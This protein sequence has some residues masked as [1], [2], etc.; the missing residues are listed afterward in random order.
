MIRLAT[1]A[2]LYARIPTLEGN[3]KIHENG[4]TLVIEQKTA[5][6][7]AMISRLY[8][9]PTLEDNPKSWAILEDICIELC[10]G[11]LEATLQVVIEDGEGGQKLAPS[12]E[13]AEKR[14]EMIRAG[15]LDLPDA[16]RCETCSVAKGG[17]HDASEVETGVPENESRSRYY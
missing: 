4:I 9:M 13:E 3:E 16:E 1:L 10:R 8:K 15:E 17:F 6:I 14:L 12:V 2:E 7:E 11:P 5:Y